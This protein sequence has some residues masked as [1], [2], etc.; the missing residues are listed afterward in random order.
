MM[1]WGCQMNVYDAQR[2]ADLMASCGYVKVLSPQEADVVIL[3]TCAVRAKAEDKVFNQIASWQHQKLLKDDAVLCLGGCVGA[4]LKDQLLAFNP[5]LNVIFGPRT[6]HRLPALIRQYLTDGRPVALVDADALE[7]FDA[8]PSAMQESGP[9]AFVTIMEGCSNK[10]SYCIVPYTRGSE[11][12]RP[13]KDVLE[14][15]AMHLANGA[16]EIHLLGQNVNSYRGLNEDGSVA[17]FSELLYETAALPGIK[18]LRFTTSNPMEFTDDIVEAVGVLDVIAD[19]VHVPV[20]SGSDRILQLMRRHYT[21]DDYLT[22]VSKLRK[23]R[24]KIQI[25]SDFI[26][27]FPGESEQDFNDTLDIV[28][29]VQFDLSFSFIYSKRPG[30]PAAL[31]DDDTPAEVKKERLYKLQEKLES[32]AALHTQEYLGTEQEV[33]IEGVSRKDQNELKGRASN[34]RIVV[35]KGT[36]DLIG[37]MAKVK[38]MSLSA[39]TLK[40]ELT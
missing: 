31:M 15:A 35:F 37:S 25:S 36:P 13:I 20:Q 34:G 32:Y 40:G 38:V 19:A 22:I 12:S 2:I 26:V 24:P 8:L 30:T 5:R 17:T 21:R 33:L 18:R 6:A 7:K 3:I 9:S 27:G 10:C 1:V 14:E 16:K 11:L 39:H 28:D 29:K 23:V 4:E